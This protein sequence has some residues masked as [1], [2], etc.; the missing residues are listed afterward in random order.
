MSSTLAHFASCIAVTSSLSNFCFESKR[1]LVT[2]RRKVDR[3]VIRLVIVQVVI[4]VLD[5]ALGQ[6]Q[7]ELPFAAFLDE[8]DATRIEDGLG[9]RTRLNMRGSIWASSAS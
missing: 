7:V 5:L 3:R 2:S 9:M 6:R 4:D 1:S 8:L